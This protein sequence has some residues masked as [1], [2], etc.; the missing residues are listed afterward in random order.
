[1]HEISG[2]LGKVQKN[3]Y[4]VP[5]ISKKMKVKQNIFKYPVISFYWLLHIL[6]Y[7]EGP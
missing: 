2:Y 7:P 3:V 4:I 6:K 1:M 5:D